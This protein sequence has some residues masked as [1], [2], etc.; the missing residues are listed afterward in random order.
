LDRGIPPPVGGETDEGSRAWVRAIGCPTDDAGHVLA[1]RFGG[2]AFYNN[3]FGNIFPQD[4]S[5]NR[6]HPMRT[7]DE[8]VAD[9]HASGADVCVLIQLSYEPADS[10][11]PTHAA[12][13][14]RARM[15]G[16]PDF[17]PVWDTVIR[18]ESRDEG[19]TA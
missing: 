6:G 16:L 2:F 13:F 18:N 3:P 17:V 11:R 14:T 7:A 5:F 4:L 12:Y 15:P 10:L 1:K 19:C 8:T 9:L